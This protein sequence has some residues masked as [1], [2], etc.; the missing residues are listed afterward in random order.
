M[1]IS[2]SAH[3]PMS[4]LIQKPSILSCLECCCNTNSLCTFPNIGVKQ[5]SLFAIID[6]KKGGIK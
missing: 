6:N 5:I 2:H 3:C 4:R 1:I